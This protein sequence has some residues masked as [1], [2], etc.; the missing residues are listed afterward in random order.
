MLTQ[1]KEIHIS[2]FLKNSIFYQMTRFDL[3][4]FLADDNI[5]KKMSVMTTMTLSH[6][7]PT[8]SSESG[9]QS[10]LVESIER[11]SMATKKKKH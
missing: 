7:L 5:A 8:S 6:C 4:F 11:K 1:M 2:S 3:S 9:V 10:L